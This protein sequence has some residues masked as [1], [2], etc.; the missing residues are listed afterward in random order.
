MQGKLTADLKRIIASL[1][2]RHPE[3]RGPFKITVDLAAKDAVHD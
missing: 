2:M 3:L 1:S